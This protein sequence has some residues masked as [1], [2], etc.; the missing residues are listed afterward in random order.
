[1]VGVLERFGDVP[2]GSFGRS[3]LGFM[4]FSAD[5]STLSPRP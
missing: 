5:Y 4:R 1:M 3:G 2:L